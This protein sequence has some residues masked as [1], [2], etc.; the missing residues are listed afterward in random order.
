MSLFVSILAVCIL[1]KLGIRTIE[2]CLMV[3][4]SPLF[5]ACLVADATR[6]IF[7]RFIMNFITTAFQTVFM[8][9]IYIIGIEWMQQYAS[10]DETDLLLWI[11]GSLSWP[12]Y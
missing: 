10:A 6:P 3:I 9:I 7:K 8:S 5:F 11:L 12:L 4:I 1:V 2:L